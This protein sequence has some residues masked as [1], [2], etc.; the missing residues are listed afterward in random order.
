[1]E[2]KTYTLEELKKL[3]KQEILKIQMVQLPFSEQVVNYFKNQLKKT[4][5]DEKLD[6][7]E[8]WVTLRHPRSPFINHTTTWT[9]ARQREIKNLMAKLGI[10]PGDIFSYDLLQGKSKD[11]VLKMS[12]FELCLPEEKKIGKILQLVKSERDITQAFLADLLNIPFTS[13]IDSS[14]TYINI[15]AT[16]AKTIADIQEYILK[17]GFEMKEYPF[18]YNF[19]IL[20]AMKAEKA[21]EDLLKELTTERGFDEE[22]AARFV[23]IAKEKRWI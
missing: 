14:Q 17:L 23:Q 3:P 21:A 1:M 22:V 18:L 15:R 2:L 12:L 19:D 5:H 16:G 11:D 6:K 7:L 10:I 9:G 20:K 8:G 4:H 13:L